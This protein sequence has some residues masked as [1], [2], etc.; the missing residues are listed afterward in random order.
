MN[1]LNYRIVVVAVAIVVA[2]AFAMYAWD[3][4]L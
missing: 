3:N 2:V 4:L 1:D